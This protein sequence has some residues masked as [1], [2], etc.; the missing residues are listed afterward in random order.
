MNL[1]DCYRLLGLKSEASLS[2]V[3]ASYR[4]LAMQYHPDVNSGDQQSHNKF[5]EVTQAY[6][7]I[8][9]GV[10]SAQPEA[11]Y[12]KPNTVTT[13]APRAGQPEPQ[14]SS[15]P[16]QN[17]SPSKGGTKVTRKEVPHSKAGLSE[18]EQ[19]LKRASYQQLQQLLKVQQFLRAIALAESLA[20]RLPRDPEVRQWQAITYQCRGRQLIKEKQFTKARSYLKKALRTDPHNRALW[21]SVEEDFR[22]LEPI[23]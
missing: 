1:G 16:P 8:L 6:K 3:K 14:V 10:G 2:E 17:P 18:A 11:G 15:S 20:Q 21:T 13:P 23:L 7:F 22:R 4:R 19:Q 5:I 12:P 9:S